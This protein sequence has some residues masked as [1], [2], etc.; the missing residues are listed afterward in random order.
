LDIE[1]QNEESVTVEKFSFNILTNYKDKENVIIGHAKS[2]AEFEFGAGEK[3]EVPISIVTTLEDNPDGK[4]Y[5]FVGPI[6]K[7]L[8]TNKEMEFLLE[9]YVEYNTIVGKINI[10]ISEVFK[11]KART[12]H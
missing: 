11:T 6:L 2:P 8:V 12:K 5:E 4:A 7:S 3:R 9:G 1:N 10:P